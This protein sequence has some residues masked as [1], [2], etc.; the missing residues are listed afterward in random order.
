MDLGRCSRCGKFKS[1]AEFAWHHKERGQRR[2]CCRACQ[3]RY[4]R[5]HYEKHK[6]RYVARAV[7]RR[8]ALTAQRVAYLVALF[9][10]N[11]CADCGESDPLVLEFDHL[12]DK[13][14]NIAKGITAH[15]WQALVDEI[16]KCEVVC[17]NCHRR[18]TAARAGSI[19]FTLAQGQGLGESV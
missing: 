7:R 8:K 18:R 17:A 2:K 12:A 1:A 15:S 10:A 13:K 9:H 3:S 6:E 16:A 4:S 19:R 5:Q 14:F 11:P